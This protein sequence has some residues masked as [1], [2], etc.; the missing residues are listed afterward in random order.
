MVLTPGTRFA[1]YE[2]GPLPGPTFR[3]LHTHVRFVELVRAIGLP[4]A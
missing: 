4:A 3:P 1:A 2:L